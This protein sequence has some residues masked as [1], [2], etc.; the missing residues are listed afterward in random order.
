M[1]EQRCGW[2]DNPTPANWWIT[3]REGEW[4]IGVQG[5]Y[6]ADGEMPDFDEQWVETNVHHG[7]GCACMH[8]RVDRSA[9]RVITYRDVKALP[10]EQ[11]RTDKTLQHRPR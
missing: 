2:V 9:K 4:E 3:D 7:Y 1:F 6:Q 8:V 5:G 11:C 10:I